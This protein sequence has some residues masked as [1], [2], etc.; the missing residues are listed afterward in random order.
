MREDKRGETPRPSRGDARG[1]GD[2]DGAR[3]HLGLPPPSGRRCIVI[4]GVRRRDLRQYFPLAA[5]CARMRVIL[6]AHASRLPARRARFDSFRPPRKSH[7]VQVWRPVRASISR[8]ADR[9]NHE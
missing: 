3:A 2:R 1:T 7:L 9:E 6:V 8:V 4:H 5:K